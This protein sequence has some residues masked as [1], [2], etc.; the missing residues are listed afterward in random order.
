MNVPV[1]DDIPPKEGWYTSIAFAGF[2]NQQVEIIHS[3]IGLVFKRQPSLFPEA[4][5]PAADPSQ[6][7]SILKLFVWH[8]QVRGVTGMNARPSRPCVQQESQVVF[9][10]ESWETSLTSDAGSTMVV[11]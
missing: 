8:L 5:R 11:K 1:V 4:G 3:D 2:C 10:L 9:Q 7:G 6:A